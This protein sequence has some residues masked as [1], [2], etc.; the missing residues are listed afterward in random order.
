[1]PLKPEPP[2]TKEELKR[3]VSD[4]FYAASQAASFGYLRLIQGA[5]NL[6][7]LAP[8]FLASTHFCTARFS[9]YP[10]FSSERRPSSLRVATRKM[11][12]TRFLHTDIFPTGRV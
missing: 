7:T 12:T 5:L 11:R 10:F 1:M 9:S 8:R 6:L 3:A 4:L 2:P